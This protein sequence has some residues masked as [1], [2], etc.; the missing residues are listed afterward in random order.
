MTRVIT[1]N[2]I[3]GYHRWKDA[4]APVS[5]LR[6]WHRHVFHVRCWFEVSHDDREIEIIMK[7]WEIEN[8]LKEKYG[9]PCWFGEM[10]CESIAREIV[11]RFGAVQVEVLEDGFGGAN[12][13]R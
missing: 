6:Q 12:V 13:G 8:F 3:E 7:Q 10:S 4:P 5:F 9:N 11:D 1:H 2:L